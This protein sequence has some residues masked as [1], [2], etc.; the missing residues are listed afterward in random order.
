VGA[1]QEIIPKETRSQDGPKQW[2]CKICNIEV[3][4]QSRDSHLSEY[5]H[6]VASHSQQEE[7]R[8][9]AYFSNHHHNNNNTTTTTTTPSLTQATILPANSG[10][11][12][13]TG[14]TIFAAS[15]MTEVYGAPGVLVWQCT[16]C[17]CC[18]PLSV[19]QLHLSSVDHIQKLLEMIKITCM[20]IP[21]SQVQVPN[22]NLG[23]KD[24]L[25]Y[26]VL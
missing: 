5:R 11:A 7:S 2:T 15:D 10:V 26:E 12:G 21:E 4:M 25:D 22:N 1:Y 13:I 14:D 3:L 19:K 9:G 23:T 16:L 17:N 20:T 6:T 8:H 18:V 24:R